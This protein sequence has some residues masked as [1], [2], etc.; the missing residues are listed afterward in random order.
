VAE[1]WLGL[2]VYAKEGRKQLIISQFKKRETAL[3]AEEK[4]NPRQWKVILHAHVVRTSGQTRI[5]FPEK[6]VDLR[7]TIVEIRN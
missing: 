4:V 3:V 2:A 5:M 6:S 1:A 7:Q